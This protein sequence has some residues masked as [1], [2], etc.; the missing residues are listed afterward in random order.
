MIEAEEAAGLVASDGGVIGLI[1]SGCVARAN[2]AGQ[3]GTGA[4]DEV[5]GARFAD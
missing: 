3:N 4:E 2:E 1:I 5:V